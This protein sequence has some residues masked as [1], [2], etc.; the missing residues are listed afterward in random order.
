MTP[1]LLDEIH[2]LNSMTTDLHAIGKILI[3]W[4]LFYVA[5]N[6]LSAIYILVKPN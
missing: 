4:F 3:I 1:D 5:K 6:A 2:C